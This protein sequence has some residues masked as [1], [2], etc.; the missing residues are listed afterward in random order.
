MAKAKITVLKKTVNQDVVDAYMGDE[1]RLREGG[2]ACSVF[3]EGDEFVLDSWG[4]APEGFCNWAWADLHKYILMIMGGGGYE[5]P[6][7]IPQHAAI[8]C[9]TDGYRPVIFK[10]ER[11][12]EGRG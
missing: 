9:C 3:E 4:V 7:T 2:I 1:F 8:G 11:I 12:E 5:R 6:W 10:I